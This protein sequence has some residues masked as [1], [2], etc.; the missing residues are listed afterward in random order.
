MSARPKFK[1]SLD[2]ETIESRIMLSSVTS[3]LAS[4]PAHGRAEVRATS[5]R[6]GGF[7]PSSQ[8]IAVPQNQGPQGLNEALT[9]T[10]NLTPQQQRREQF[11]GVFK[12]PYVIGPGITDTQW[13]QVSIRGAG[14]TNSILHGDLQLKIIV[15]KD[16]TQ[17]ISAVS[18]IFDRNI[19]S[20]STLGFDLSAPQVVNG[21]PANLDSS[22]RPNHLSQ[23]A[24]DVNTSGGAYAE[25]YS[26]GIVDIKYLPSPKHAPGSISQG[27]AI[28]RIRAQIYTPG[29]SNL[30]ANAA[31]NPG[32]PSQGGVSHKPVS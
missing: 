6:S 23:V 19:N 3:I 2:F 10:G 30:L 20:N 9:P 17:P 16:P 4:T 1:K 22:G 25:A 15:P 5:I 18:A 7:T 31:L 8:S 21:V 32:G 26:Q 27:T 28:V 12:G 24:I 29:V 11:V 13:Q 14:G